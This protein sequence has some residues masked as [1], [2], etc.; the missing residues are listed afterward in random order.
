V[1][2]VDGRARTEVGPAP[3]VNLVGARRDEDRI[4][5]AAVAELQRALKKR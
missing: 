5:L 4:L 2:H 1:Y 3:E